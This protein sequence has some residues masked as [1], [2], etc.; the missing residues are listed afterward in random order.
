MCVG[1][2]EIFN[3]SGIVNALRLGWKGTVVE[4]LGNEPCIV[5]LE[6]LRVAEGTVGPHG[7]GLANMIVMLPGRSILSIANSIPSIF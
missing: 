1:V 2:G 7:A 6:I 3:H 5:Q 4:H